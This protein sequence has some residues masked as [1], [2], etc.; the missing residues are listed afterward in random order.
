MFA[1]AV[2][3]L[4]RRRSARSCVRL[5]AWWVLLRDQVRR[6][7][8]QAVRAGRFGPSE[9]QAVF[10]MA[11]RLDERTRATAVVVWLLSRNPHL[12]SL[13][14]LDS[15]GRRQRAEC[16]CGARPQLTF[17]E[18]ME[19]PAL[20]LHVKHA[21]LDPD[22]PSRCVADCFLVQSVLV[23][24]IREQNGKGL[25]V[26]LSQAIFKY[27][28]LWQ[29]R[30]SGEAMVQRLSKLVWHRDTRRRF[31]R[32]LRSRWRLSI[33]ALRVGRDLEQGCIRSRVHMATSRC[34]RACIGHGP[35]L[36]SCMRDALFTG[37]V[38]SEFRGA[39]SVSAGHCLAMC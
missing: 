15:R 13:F 19:D 14:V 4:F 7:S 12:A 1:N 16:I 20:R 6:L 26:D 22:H 29:H 18:W 38:F 24:Y 2:L 33:G 34:C 31:G 28:S 37:V 8:C 10:R 32:E 23:E 3:V 9:Y 11:R 21:L 27:L 17:L 36:R 5:S 39:E 30:P 25:T 35:F